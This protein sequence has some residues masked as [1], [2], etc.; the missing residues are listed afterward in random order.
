MNEIQQTYEF[1]RNKMTMWFMM[2]ESATVTLDDS[3]VTVGQ[4]NR[5]FYGG[6]RETSRRIPYEDILGAT[7]RKTYSS[8][9][10][11]LLILAAAAQIYLL[12]RGGGS[13]GATGAIVFSLLLVRKSAIQI[14]LKNGEAVNIRAKEKEKMA[15]VIELING[16]RLFREELTHGM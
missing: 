13:A 11:I 10:M 5:T 8:G 16:K 12:S 3:A 1:T 4:L 7:M 6:K 14:R 2:Q 9:W 15:V